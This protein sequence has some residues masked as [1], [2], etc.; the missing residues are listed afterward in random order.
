MV[1]IDQEA[2]R[3]K[4]FTVPKD[5]ESFSIA[6]AGE[7][8]GMSRSKMWLLRTV[9]KEIKDFRT[10]GRVRISRSEIEKYLAKQMKSK[11]D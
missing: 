9:T 5:L 7:I 11:E 8:L 2:T 3:Q 10:G 1:Q 4:K 6:E